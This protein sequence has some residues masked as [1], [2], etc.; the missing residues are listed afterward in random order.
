MEPAPAS[1]GSPSSGSPSSGAS[2]PRDAARRELLLAL[3]L[4]I[5]PGHL[6]PGIM[7]LLACAFPLLYE[8][9]LQP[10]VIWSPRVIAYALLGLAAGATCRALGTQARRRLARWTRPRGALHARLR[11]HL[12]A[13][14]L[15]TALE[16]SGPTDQ[17]PRGGGLPSPL[18]EYTSATA[19]E[20]RLWAELRQDPALATSHVLARRRRL[21]QGLFDGL[22]AALG[23][24]AGVF[25]LVPP[26]VSRWPTGGA[27]S[28]GVGIA[29]A[30]LAVAA[31]SEAERQEKSLLGELV[32]ALAQRA[33]AVEPRPAPAPA[34]LAPLGQPAGA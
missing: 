26:Y 9:R 34:P 13:H 17:E 19:L 6:L 22:G 15:R 18:A 5:E 12:V 27:A 33:G 23:V 2:P 11:K 10:P 16:R 25:L 20:Q 29:F 8:G 32:A 3:S 14:G 30:L 28:L 21:L 4:L 31:W 24:W 1:F 7:A